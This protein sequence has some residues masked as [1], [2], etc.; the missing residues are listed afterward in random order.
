VNGSEPVC[1]A[2]LE[3][4]SGR[5]A[6]LY[7]LALRL[8]E[9]VPFTVEYRSKAARGY[10]LLLGAKPQPTKA[11]PLDLAPGLTAWQG[12][13]VIARQCLQ[14]L[15]ANEDCSRLG[16]DPEGVHQLRVGMRRLRAAFSLFGGVLPEEQRLHFVSELRWAQQSFGPAR[17]WDVFIG[18]TLKPLMERLP[19]DDSIASL[20]EAAERARGEAYELVAATLDERRYTRLQLQLDL[21]LESDSD[22]IGAAIEGV[23]EPGPW[24]RP[25]DEVA[26]EVLALRHRK[27]RKLA[28]RF[29]ELEDEQRHQLRINAKKARYAAEFFRG[30]FPRKVAQNYARRLA[31]MQDCL[32]S[33]N[34]AVVGRRLVEELIAA[35]AE[36]GHAHDLLTGWHAARIA[37]DMPRAA[38]ISRKV[39]KLDPFWEEA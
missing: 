8:H 16:E 37:G 4:K 11:A 1:E 17:D 15:R 30:L 7:E 19:D 23:N 9:R 31:E 3:L 2:E 20:M 14:H 13:V 5:P 33:M 18:E 12:F 27:M 24:N 34:D 39:A 22:R 28:K 26:R 35:G 10:D 6:R 25:I 38:R 36:L 29:E 21:W 32:G